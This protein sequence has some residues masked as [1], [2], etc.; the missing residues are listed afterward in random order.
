MNIIVRLRLLKLVTAAC[1]LV[2]PFIAAGQVK[3]KGTTAKPPSATAQPT[4]T[5][6]A[7]QPDPVK[8]PDRANTKTNTRP[9]D[10]KVQPIKQ[11]LK[12]PAYF[13]EFS[14]PEFLVEKVVIEHDED[15][16]GKISFQKKDFG[17][18]MTDPLEVS[19]AALTRINDALDAL[20][21]LDSTEDYQ[22]EKDYPHLGN[23]TI[24]VNKNG[25]ER[26]AKFNWT[27]NKNAKV[28]MDEYRKLSNQY[29]WK[30]DIT[31]ARE[32]Q[33]LSA[34]A[35]MDEFDSLFRRNELSDANQVVPFLKEL[36]DD[37]RIPLI[38]RNHATKLISQIVKAKN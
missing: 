5:P 1:V 19:P 6:P 30:F 8:A 28:L 23:V 22:Y 33:P 13:Y 32:N 17:E 12:A 7:T 25:K 4:P 24:R 29:V 16:K 38:A 2:F 26:T 14:R 36:S 34:P 11:T 37:E 35:L 31:V 27:V 3:K 15:G 21:F 9:V 10:T 18:P 20:N